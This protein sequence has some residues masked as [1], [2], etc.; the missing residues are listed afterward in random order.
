MMV[1]VVLPSTT[2]WYS[3]VATPRLDT[4]RPTSQMLEILS[5]SSSYSGPAP[6]QA[7]IKKI[8]R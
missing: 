2:A 4:T 1:E 3:P 7:D 8:P 6:A 5:L